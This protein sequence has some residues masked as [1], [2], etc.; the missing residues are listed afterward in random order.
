MGQVAPTWRIEDAGRDRYIV[1]DHGRRRFL[2][3]HDDYLS[4]A[5]GK[6]WRKGYLRH[7][8][9]NEYSVMWDKETVAYVV[10]S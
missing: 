4:L 7:Y 3:H 6:E 8:R 9:G 10:K 2:L 5:D 1:D